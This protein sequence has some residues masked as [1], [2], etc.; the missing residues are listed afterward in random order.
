MAHLIVV[1][2]LRVLDGRLHDL[3]ARH[4]A[5]VDAVLARPALGVAAPLRPEAFPVGVQP[6]APGLP[7]V[8]AQIPQGLHGS[9][10]AQVAQ[11]TDV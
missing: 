7:P 11:A 5:G 3:V 10:S 2:G 8:L 1:P 4:V 6:G 9:S